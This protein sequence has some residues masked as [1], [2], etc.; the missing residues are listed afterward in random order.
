MRIQNKLNDDEN[1]LWQGRMSLIKVLVCA[2]LNEA[3]ILLI[4]YGVFLCYF[5]KCIKPQS[6]GLYTILLMLIPVGV[7]LCNAFYMWMKARCTE[8]M[9]TDKAVYIK[10]G[11]ITTTVEMKPYI[12]I[13]HVKE[14]TSFTDKVLHTG[15]VTFDC[16]NDCSS[17]AFAI[18]DI[19]EYEKVFAFINEHQQKAF[20][21]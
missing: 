3:L 20:R 21:E 18:R 6:W 12:D 13:A 15:T 14:I 11:V 2:F 4:L 1:I 17:R 9:V 8:Y 19:S 5:L 16:W 7:Y 10:S